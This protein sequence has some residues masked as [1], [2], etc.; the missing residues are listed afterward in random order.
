MTLPMD[1]AFRVLIVDDDEGIRNVV[2]RLL[3]LSGMEVEA[4][5]SSREALERMSSMVFDVMVTDFVMP[6]VSGL[7][8]I[9]Q[10]RRVAPAM[11]CLIVS[12][13]P[14]PT[15]TPHDIAWLMKP[16]D[17]DALLSWIEPANADA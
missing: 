8:L 9:E 3:T 1:G 6:E 4:A 5:A 15:N 13:Q 10:A 12:G 17:I 7:E 16:L 14:R 11:R 2:R